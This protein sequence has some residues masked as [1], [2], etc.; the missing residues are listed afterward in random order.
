[1]IYNICE[2]YRVENEDDIQLTAFYDNALDAMKCFTI[3][4][5]QH[6]D[7]PEVSVCMC[8]MNDV[9]LYE[10]DIPE[11]EETANKEAKTIN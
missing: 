11:V 5:H 8:S 3:L 6:K 9:D 7:T 2:K 1:M 4:S 10:E